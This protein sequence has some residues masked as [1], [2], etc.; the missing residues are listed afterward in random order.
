VSLFPCDRRK[1]AEEGK[2][3]VFR[4]RLFVV[5]AREKP[6]G[7]LDESALRSYLCEKT[8]AGFMPSSSDSMG[9]GGRLCAAPEIESEER[10]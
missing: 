6:I 9:R 10:D 7:L 5:P 4:N 2:V 3:E 1:P 8:A